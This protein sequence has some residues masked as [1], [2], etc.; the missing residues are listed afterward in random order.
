M[1]RVKKQLEDMI[2]AACTCGEGCTL[3]E[4][5]HRWDCGAVKILDDFALLHKAHVPW[6][7]LKVGAP[8][9]IRG[10]HEGKPRY[11]GPHWVRSVERRELMN[12]EGRAFTQSDECLYRDRPK[13]PL[14]VPDDPGVRDAND[15]N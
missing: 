6:S 10:S 5:R 11:Y 9:Y 12:H 2:E 15:N 3:E 4:F 7:E 13:V 8:V 14:E 1:G